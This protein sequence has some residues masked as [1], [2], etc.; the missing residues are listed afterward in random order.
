MAP[1]SRAVPRRDVSE[2]WLLALRDPSED[3]LQR[4]QD[5]NRSWPGMRSRT[6]VFFVLLIFAISLT[7]AA[8]FARQ[9]L[10][11]GSAPQAK[12]VEPERL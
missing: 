3:P 11:A 10:T 7:L 4:T 6:T 9:A 2:L 1:T 12:P 8:L 5:L